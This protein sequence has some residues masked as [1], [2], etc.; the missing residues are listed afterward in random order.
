[1]NRFKAN[2][3][4][5]FKAETIFHLKPLEK[6]KILKSKPYIARN[7]RRE[8]DLPVSRSGNRIWLALRYSIG[9]KPGRKKNQNQVCLPHYPFQE[10]QGGISL[11]SLDASPV[12]QGNWLFCLPAGDRLKYS[13]ADCLW[14]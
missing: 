13:Q 12:C 8:K 5:L 3:K 7:T 1:M 6:Y 10:V 14:Q 9:A 11:L 4:L 2:Q